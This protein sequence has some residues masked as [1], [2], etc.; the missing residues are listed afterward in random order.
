MLTSSKAEGIFT[1]Q[2]A[3]E[4]LQAL[5][6]ITIYLLRMYSALASSLAQQRDGDSRLSRQKGATI[7]RVT[8]CSTDS[9]PV[10]T[11]IRRLADDLL[12]SAM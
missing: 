9:L 7:D 1:G 5:G 3:V 10:K 11:M 6:V 2:G 12:S 8:P 4:A